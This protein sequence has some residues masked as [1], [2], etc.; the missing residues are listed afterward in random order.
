MFFFDNG[1]FNYRSINLEIQTTII[2][3]EIVFFSLK[4]YKLNSKDFFRPYTK[5]L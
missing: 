3:P 2:A 1:S 5:Y 4:K